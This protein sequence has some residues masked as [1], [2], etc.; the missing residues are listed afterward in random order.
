MVERGQTSMR[1]VYPARKHKVTGAR[2][3]SATTPASKRAASITSVTT[4][5]KAVR[6][7]EKSAAIIA[8]VS[9]EVR[10][11]VAGIMAGPASRKPLTHQAAYD[12]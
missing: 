11:S 12:P 2:P 6:N 9:D 3:R 8:A 10:D 1:P 7:G 4:C 5:E